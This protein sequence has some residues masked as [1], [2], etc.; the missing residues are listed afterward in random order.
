MM[1]LQL[2]WHGKIQHQWSIY[3]LKQS[4]AAL[5]GRVMIIMDTIHGF[6]PMCSTNPALTIAKLKLDRASAALCSSVPFC[7]RTPL[8]SFGWLAAASG[9]PCPGGAA[10]RLFLTGANRTHG[11]KEPGRDITE[12]QLPQELDRGKR[13]FFSQRNTRLSSNAGAS[14]RMDEEWEPETSCAGSGCWQLWAG[15]AF[16][17]FCL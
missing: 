7:S 16:L 6:G 1:H 13:E 9:C 14:T 2:C 17:H 10:T 15:N 4:L 8:M 12:K 3:F 5:I 11:N